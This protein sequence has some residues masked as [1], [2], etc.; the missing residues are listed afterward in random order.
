MQWQTSFSIRPFGLLKYKKGTAARS[1]LDDGTHSAQHPHRH[2]TDACAP[3]SGGLP[4]NRLHQGGV[5]EAEGQGRS[6]VAAAGEA[7]A[8]NASQPWNIFAAF[9]R[10][11][12]TYIADHLPGRHRRQRRR[13]RRDEEQGEASGASAFFNGVTTQSCRSCACMTHLL[14][15]T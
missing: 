15:F 8:T 12:V 6:Y 13:E 7:V 4:P 1:D 9:G 14:W 10:D 11:A 2:L 5:L 3:S